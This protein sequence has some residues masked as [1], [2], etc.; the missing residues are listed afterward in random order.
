[1]S[2]RLLLLFLLAAAVSVIAAAIPSSTYMQNE[3]LRLLNT[4]IAGT[5]PWHSLFQSRRFDQVTNT[6]T[7]LPDYDT[8]LREYLHREDAHEKAVALCEAGF[9]LACQIEIEEHK[10]ASSPPGMTDTL[11]A[12]ISSHRHP[13]GFFVVSISLICLVIVIRGYVR[14]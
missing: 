10:S 13:L 7:K 14:E 9:V 5:K 1:M 2:L 8:D 6:N 12:D 3:H 4:T 11:H